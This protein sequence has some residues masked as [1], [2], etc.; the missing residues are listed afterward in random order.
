MKG[1]HAL[2]ALLGLLIA[3]PG[4]AAR[5]GPDTIVQSGFE[6]VSGA[7]IA[8]VVSGV[9]SADIQLRSATGVLVSGVVTDGLY[10]LDLPPA[11]PEAMLDLRVRGRAGSG[12]DFIELAAHVGTV[13]QLIDEADP[14]GVARVNKVPT[15]AVSPESTARYALLAPAMPLA[16]E[17]AL[18]AAV[19]QIDSDAM[20][21][22]AQEFGHN[23]IVLQVVVAFADIHVRFVQQQDRIPTRRTA[24][25][26][27]ERRFHR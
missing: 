15:L 1:I 10:Q 9:D 27:A 4:Q 13:Q 20:F 21:E 12:Q 26:G 7:R 25:N 16:H 11:A 24:Q 17:C 14:D 19:A 6:T 3:A 2:F 8:G 18:G 22:R 5:C 23:R